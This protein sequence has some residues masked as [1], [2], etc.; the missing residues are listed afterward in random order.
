[1]RLP[2]SALLRSEGDFAQ[3]LSAAHSHGGRVLRRGIYIF[4]LAGTGPTQLGITVAKKLLKRAVDRNRVKRIIR[5]W[6]RKNR[7]RLEGQILVRLASRPEKL[8]SA[9]LSFDLESLA[10]WMEGAARK[11]S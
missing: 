2:K 4:Y 10:V 5:D 3:V 8:D 11:A 6:Y 9:T 1:M 7:K